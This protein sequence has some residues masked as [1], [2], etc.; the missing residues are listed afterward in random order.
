MVKSI[1]GQKGTTYRW[2]DIARPW[3]SIDS[4][5]DREMPK[6]HCC[7]SEEEINRCLSCTRKKCN[8]YVNCSIRLGVEPRKNGRP[9]KNGG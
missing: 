2:E 6:I 8:G 5:P 9:K 4:P 7:D 1:T 3:N